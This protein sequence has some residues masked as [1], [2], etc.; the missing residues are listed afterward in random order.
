MARVI[1]SGLSQVKKKLADYSKKVQDEVKLQV[2]DSST[3][4]EI[5]AQNKAPIG[6][7]GL[8]D[9]VVKNNGYAS[10]IGV[11]SSTN[12]PVYIEFGTGESAASYVPTLPREIQEYAR[13]FYENGQGTMKKQ[14]YLIPSFLAESP[15]FISELKKIL[16][17][18]V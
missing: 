18:N 3:A 4:I 9:K 1:I 14:P 2:L 10:E 17:N 13:Q 5:N 16:K 11:Q 12:I 15:I 7:K 8:I 6:I